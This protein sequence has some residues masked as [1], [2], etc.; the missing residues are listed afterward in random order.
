MTT[1]ATPS[2]DLCFPLASIGV[3]LDWEQIFGDGGLKF[4]TPKRKKSPK[5]SSVPVRH[6][7][8]EIP[9]EKT[10][11]KYQRLRNGKHLRYLIMEILAQALPG[12]FICYFM[13]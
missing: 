10:E 13:F 8:R 6:L 11:Q 5:A 12:V 9:E 7:R 3:T 1:S 4:G 2:L